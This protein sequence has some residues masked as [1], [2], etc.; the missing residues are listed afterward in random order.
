MHSAGF[1]ISLIVVYGASYFSF[2]YNIFIDIVANCLTKSIFENRLHVIK[3]ISHFHLITYR[4][5]NCSGK[6]K[7]IFMMYN[8]VDVI[9]TLQ[10][11]INIMFIL[12]KN[13][14]R[15]LYVIPKK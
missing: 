8:N 6:C 11:N 4:D 13:N 14:C 15:N 12:H 2:I 1:I 7:K 3:N 9:S 10:N 5:L